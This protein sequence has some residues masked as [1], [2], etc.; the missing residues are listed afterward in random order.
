MQI[1]RPA[2][3]KSLA[4][5]FCLSDATA[6]GHDR[7][8]R[9]PQRNLPLLLKTVDFMLRYLDLDGRLAAKREAGERRARQQ[10]T[11]QTVK[12]GGPEARKIWD[13]DNLFPKRARIRAFIEFL[14][15][16]K[17]D[18]EL[19]DKK[20]ASTMEGFA[21]C[22][23]CGYPVPLVRKNGGRYKFCS[24]CGANLEDAKWVRADD[25]LDSSKDDYAKQ[26]LVDAFAE[27]FPKI[28]GNPGE[29]DFKDLKL[30]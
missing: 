14:K 26:D 1:W 27:A 23:R 4:D 3:I 8:P 24:E 10:A 22:P 2:V 13:D 19:F 30:F 18:L 25:L 16:A 29:F 28:F 11:L 5:K 9:L 7:K 6:A 12:A 21:L 17:P 15:S 20:F